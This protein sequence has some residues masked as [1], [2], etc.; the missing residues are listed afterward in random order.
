MFLCLVLCGEVQCPNIE[1]HKIDIDI[2]LQCN[3]NQGES[4]ESCGKSSEWSKF[5]LRKICMQ[6]NFSGRGSYAGSKK[7]CGPN[8][9]SPREHQHQHQ[10]QM[11]LLVVILSHSKKQLVNQC[12]TYDIVD[13][14]AKVSRPQRIFWSQPA[15][16]PGDQIFYYMWRKGALA[17][18]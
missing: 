5:I 3:G 7:S 17:R 1:V 14:E 13:T 16:F 11:N 8:A 12:N 4:Y 2:S 9:S 15:S 18:K 6:P 10:V